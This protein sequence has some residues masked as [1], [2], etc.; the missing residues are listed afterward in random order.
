MGVELHNFHCHCSLRHTISAITD[1]D[2]RRH[3]CLQSRFA[4]PEP[5]DSEN[6]PFWSLISMQ[7]PLWIVKSYMAFLKDDSFAHTS[8]KWG[9]ASRS[10]V[11]W[12]LF[13][14]LE[15]VG[16]DSEDLKRV[17]AHSPLRQKHTAWIRTGNLPVI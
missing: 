8:C 15:M 13:C 1:S 10:E 12:E 4:C 3:P 11:L 7:H 2:E 14:L 16:F 17:G 5:F 9:W 6:Y